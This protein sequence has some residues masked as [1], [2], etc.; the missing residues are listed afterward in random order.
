M[1]RLFGFT[2][3]TALG[4]FA[5]GCAPGGGHSNIYT[6]LFNGNVSLSVTMTFVSVIASLAMLPLW[7][8]TL[9][10]TLLDKDTGVVI[11]FSRIASSLFIIIVPLIIGIFIGRFKPNVAAVIRKI[12]RPFFFFVVIVFFPI[13]I[14][15]NI[16]VIRMF[17]V[18]VVMA[19][20][21]LPY[22]G[23]LLGAVLSAVCRQSRARIITI[24]LETGIQNIG[25]P[26][27]VMQNSLPH[28]ESEIAMIGPI[29]VAIAT[30]LPLW[31]GLTIQEV[32]RRCCRGPPEVTSDQD[33]KEAPYLKDTE[34]NEKDV[35]ASE[36]LLAKKTQTTKE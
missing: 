25:I 5:V 24:A 12:L 19:G 23:F 2:H 18:A 14:Y 8:L 27:L 31:L 15:M 36:D 30:P 4:Y 28:P 21:C 29:A 20:C 22:I 16:A 13:A 34:V 1:V 9:G 3:D 7:L 35:E 32:R 26:I 11:P 10:Q 33:T 17:T 6:F